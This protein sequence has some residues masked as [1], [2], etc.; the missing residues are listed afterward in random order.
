MAGTNTKECTNL[1]ESLIKPKELSRFRETKGRTTEKLIPSKKQKLK[2][3]QRCNV[4]KKLSRKEIAKMGLYSL[5]VDTI[6]YEQMQPLNRLWRGYMARYLGKEKLPDESDAQ[7]N[8]FT[9]DFLRADFHGAK[10]SVTRAKNPSLVGIKGIV[11]LDTKGTFK[12]VS[13]DNKVRTIP[14]AD[15]VFQISWNNVDITVFGKHLNSRPAER[16]VKKIKTFLE[17]DLN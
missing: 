1:M 3:D 10:M 4:P 15:S 17:C 2:S 9:L 16:S 11:I 5:P 12:F 8:Q 13:K 14:K 7:Y 6:R